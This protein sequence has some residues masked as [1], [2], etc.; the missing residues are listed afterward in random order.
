MQP[1]VEESC[2]AE[3]LSRLL[4]N[5]WGRCGTEGLSSLYN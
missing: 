2:G 5:V 1:G 4:N 3:G